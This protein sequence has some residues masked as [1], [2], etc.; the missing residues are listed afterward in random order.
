M[1]INNLTVADVSVFFFF[2]GGIL[3]LV[4]GFCA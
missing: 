4:K 1:A 2:F 3:C